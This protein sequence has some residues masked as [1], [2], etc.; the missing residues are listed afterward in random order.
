MFGQFSAN[1]VRFFIQKRLLFFLIFGGIVAFLIFGVTRLKIE[2][3]LYSVFPDGK[4]YQEFSQILQKNNLNKQV[5]F[6]VSAGEDEDQTLEILDQIVSDLEK[7]FTAEL[8]DFVVYRTVDEK[9]LIGYLQSSAILHMDTAD[10]NEIDRRLSKDSIEKAISKAAERLEGTNG[11]FMRSIIAKD[12]LGL[13]YNKLSQL[14]PVNDS[15]A[16]VIKDGLVYTRDE[17][18]ILFFATLKIDLKNTDRLTDFNTKLSAHASKVNKKS[19]SQTL[20]YFGTFQIAAEN[21]VQVKKDTSTTTYVS[22]GLI[23]LL[24]V[25][26]YRSIL[27]P[28]YFILPAIFG[29]LCGGGMVG[30]L[31]P[32]I[33]AI[34][35]AT[36]SV[37]LG[38]V[39]DYSF[40][41]FTHFKHSGNLLE[42]IREISAPMIVG[43]FTTVA[44]LAALMYTDS[45]V[46]QDFGLI[47][48]CVLSGS[49]IFTIFFLPVVIHTLRIKLPDTK[50]KT[51]SIKVSKAFVRMGIMLITVITFIFMFEGFNLSFDADLNNLSFH[52]DE[53]KQKEEFFTGINPAAEK[54]IYIIASSKSV[55]EAKEVNARIYAVA[56]ANKE[57]FGIS[58]LVSMAPYLV[59][60]KRLES[61]RK[62][63]ESYWSGKKDSIQALIISSGKHYHFSDIA[64]RPFY[65]WMNDG[66]IDAS[67]G[68]EL[69]EDL[70][71]SKFQYDDGGETTFITSIV[72]DRKHLSA[73]KEAFR[74]VEGVYI[75]DIA[76]IT[77]KM[78]NSV[79]NDF[80]YLL[81]FSALLVFI[82]LLVVYGRIELALFAFLPMVLGWIWIL[83]LTNLLDLKF[84]FVNIV[85]ATF[86]FGLG[87]DFSIFTTDGLIQRYK[88]GTDILKSY[89]SAIVLSGITTIIGTGALY[90]AKHPAIHSI[91]LISVVGI[92][93]ILIIT[94]F[95][96]PLIFN[97]FVTN[98][99]KKGRVPVT[100][101]TLIYSCLLF[102]YFF[103]GSVLLNIFF[104]I[105]ILPFPAPKSR[106][107]AFLNYLVSK[108]AKSTLY[109]GVHV[110]KRVLHPEKLDFSRPSVIVANHSS[111]LDI[112]LVVM[113]NPKVI[114]MVKSWVYNSPVF[115]LFIRYAGY[116]FAEEGTEANLDFIKRRVAE[117]YSIVVFPEGTRSVDGQIKRFH[118]GAFFIAKE[119]D[120]DI[121]PILLIGAHE[122]NPKNDILI[123][124]G[125]LVVLPL[126]RISSPK[127]ESYTQLTKR[128]T[129][130]MREG[131]TAG[132]RTHAKTAFWQPMLL[133]NYILKGPVLEWYVRVKWMLEKKNFEYYDA[134]IGD[135]TTIYD[136]GCG[137]GYLS[138]Y[139]HYRNLDRVITAVDYDAEKISIAAHGIQKNTNL[140]FVD[141]DI[142]SFGF[143]P[144]D[145]VFLNDV[146]HYLSKKDQDLVL[147]A[148]A[149][150]LNDN[151]I[152]FI[153]D[154][155]KEM[156]A[157]FK[158]TKFTEFLSTKV[159]KFN[160]VTNDLEFISEAEMAAFAAKNGFTMEKVEHSKT[161][162]NVLL[163]LRKGTSGRGDGE[164]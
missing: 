22:L 49:V 63:W 110:K 98:R 145:V 154:G 92:S 1:I 47:A 67:R 115:G 39:L 114:I 135:R 13:T 146:L 11:F 83:G 150:K 126:D 68:N 3:D 119:L 51:A 25:L 138:Y 78:L 77:E 123:S 103:V 116:P 109:A 100:F 60:E 20:E 84:N 36:S 17:K 97:F 45:V 4:E 151:G 148:I 81:L 48:L 118:K 24:L 38:I 153:R 29:M 2:E 82:S 124:K 93:C 21:A 43:S 31:N 52:S 85:I 101:F 32:E 122:V 26:Y 125:H 46:L 128:V 80:N 10:Y 40:H 69:A 96:Q 137:Y 71:L 41:F 147:E 88:T 65:A 160:K 117:G 70:G 163:I 61:A 155:I 161:T 54:K 53:L 130:L 121:Q 95:L 44:A 142:R 59:P 56:I 159:F 127:N 94:L 111:F 89:R 64:F 34:S 87:D 73:C 129:H 79:Q 106:K 33:S 133:K 14:N 42:T 18:K 15:S 57:R 131:Y 86:I 66:T 104:V 107:R 5:V 91:A 74:Q 152:L 105:F 132:K 157:R 8:G 58:E 6:A 72:L 144:M 35:L 16:Y 139:L 141:A 27:A 23:L 113:L 120:L 158:K 76:D 140:S 90:F 134:L 9:A 55:E 19:G 50:E 62:T 28:F 164:I 7:K 149:E 162:S 12:P 37:L 99:V 30:Y 156:E 108:L 136:F 75:L 112:L 102:L 143:K